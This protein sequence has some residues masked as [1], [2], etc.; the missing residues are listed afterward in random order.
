[1]PYIFPIAVIANSLSMTAMLILFS[2]AGQSHFSA[3]IGIAQAATTALFYAFSAN[4]RVTV[5][6]SPNSSLAKSL[7]DIRATL[8]VPLSLAAFWLTSTLGGVEPYLACILILRRVV[9]W[10]VEVDL[11]EKERSNN[12]RFALTFVVAQTIL[13]VIGFFWFLTVKIYPLLGLFLWA[14]FPLL[15][16]FNFLWIALGSLSKEMATIRKRMAPHFGSSFALGVSLYVFRLLVIALWGKNMSG[17]LFAAFAIG[18]VAG[19][20]FVGAFGPSIAFNEKRTGVFQL[21]RLLT[22]ILWVFTGLGLA[23]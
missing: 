21:P 5:L 8:L 4:S 10:L 23:I 12:Q 15:L 16:S 2:L 6:A 9:E 7:L 18:G 13:L 14:L 11:S 19:S 17:D 1:M 20:V 3:D 22:V